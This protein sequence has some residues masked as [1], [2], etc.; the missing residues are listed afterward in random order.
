MQGLQERDHGLGPQGMRPGQPARA[1]LPQ[2]RG[3]AADEPPLFPTVKAA[4]RWAWQMEDATFC[5]SPQYG[6]PPPR[7]A[8]TLDGLTVQER[9]AQ[10]AWI[11]QTAERRLQPAEL[12]LVLALFAEGPMR[13][14]GVRAVVR[15]VCLM[16]RNRDLGREV[17]RRHLDL[18]RANRRTLAD[19][20]DEFGVAP[21]TVERLAAEI[22]RE[23]D[24]RIAGIERTLSHL[25]VSTGV[26]AQ[27]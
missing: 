3:T 27:V 16:A 20:A 18:G 12:S 11:R 13:G 14:A 7:R 26:A 24:G 4:L 8:S 25:F 23:I 22:G 17:A 1:P 5:K 2:L 9:V 19:I 21:R 10:A 15:E 6:P